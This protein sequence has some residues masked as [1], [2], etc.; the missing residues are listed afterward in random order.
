[1]GGASEQDE[2][3]LPESI[4]MTVPSLGRVKESRDSRVRRNIEVDHAKFPQG[5]Y[6]PVIHSSFRGYFTENLTE[7]TYICF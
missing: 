3:V 1:M 2:L 5:V 7:V 6:V 4:S